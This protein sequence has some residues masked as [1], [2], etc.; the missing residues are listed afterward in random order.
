MQRGAQLRHVDR[1]LCAAQRGLEGGIVGD[2][3]ER[4]LV[5]AEPEEC[6]ARGVGKVVDNVV[7]INNKA[8]LEAVAEVQPE[9]D[10]GGDEVER[11][12]GLVCELLE[13][14]APGPVGEDR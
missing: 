11:I 3:L 5:G 14:W 1:V 2:G 10:R 13:V 6:V 8:Q 7:V 4:E 9:L 12:V